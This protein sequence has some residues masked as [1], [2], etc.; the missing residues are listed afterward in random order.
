MW[1]KIINGTIKDGIELI[2]KVLDDECLLYE[3]V[4]HVEA[5]YEGEKYIIREHTP[6]IFIQKAGTSGYYLHIDSLD[7]E[8]NR[9]EGYVIKFSTPIDEVMKAQ[10]IMNQLLVRHC[11]ESGEK[12]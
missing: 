9:V 8:F 7:E 11:N 12:C 4:F 2:K 10:E 1:N 6:V 3:Y 5:V